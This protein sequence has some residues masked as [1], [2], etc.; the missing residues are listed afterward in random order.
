MPKE[1]NKEEKVSNLTAILA[2]D[3]QVQKESRNNNDYSV[4]TSSEAIKFNRNENSAMSGAESSSLYHQKR[5][6]S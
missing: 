3:Q 2:K 5:P 4:G 6:M 1:I